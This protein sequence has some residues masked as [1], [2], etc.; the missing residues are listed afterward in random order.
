MMTTLMDVI[1]AKVSAVAA[2]WQVSAAPLGGSAQLLISAYKWKTSGRVQP[3]PRGL[4]KFP[5]VTAASIG[6]PITTKKASATSVDRR[7][8]SIRVHRVSTVHNKLLCA[9]RSLY[10]TINNQAGR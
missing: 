6:A 7:M 2:I 8:L 1:H 9:Q 5:E 10:S 3:A 4:S